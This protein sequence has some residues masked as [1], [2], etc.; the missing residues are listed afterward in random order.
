MAN[1]EFRIW[2]DLSDPKM[3]RRFSLYGWEGE[4]ISDYDPVKN[5]FRIGKIVFRKPGFMSLHVPVTEEYMRYS[6]SEHII[7]H[8]GAKVLEH[9]QQQLAERGTPLPMITA[10]DI[11]I[12]TTITDVMKAATPDTPE[13]LPPSRQHEADRTTEASGE[14][15][16]KTMQDAYD[17]IKNSEPNDLPDLYGGIISPQMK[18]ALMES[19]VFPQMMET[20]IDHGPE[21]EEEGEWEI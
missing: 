10:K 9:Q 15:T 13:P 3:H 12:K 7:S 6:S 19:I 20:E 1:A 4:Y 8:I 11:G 16:L 17:A 14:L 5:A 18:K 2:D 21:A